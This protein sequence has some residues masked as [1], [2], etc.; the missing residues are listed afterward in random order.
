MTVDV[1]GDEAIVT[2]EGPGP[3]IDDP[4]QLPDGLCEGGRG[5]FLIQTLSRDYYRRRTAG[6]IHTTVVL[7]LRRRRTV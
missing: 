5:L 1:A 2:L 7:G 6:G 3:K 4:S